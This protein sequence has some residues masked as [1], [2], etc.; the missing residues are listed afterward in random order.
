MHIAAYLALFFYGPPLALSTPLS[1]LS[2]TSPRGNAPMVMHRSSAHSVDEPAA[3]IHLSRRVSVPDP[4]YPVSLSGGTGVL[5]GDTQLYGRNC[6]Y[7]QDSCQNQALG[8]FDYDGCLTT[9]GCAGDSCDRPVLP[10]APPQRSGA[11]CFQCN[12]YCQW[13]VVAISYT[14]DGFTFEQCL[15]VFGCDTC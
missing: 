4:D 14:E 1:S 10:A 5:P 8:A 9:G 15:I 7:C 12:D 2:S 13:Q 11:S 6:Q 3:N